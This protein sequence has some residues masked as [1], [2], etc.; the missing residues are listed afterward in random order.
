MNSLYLEEQDITLLELLYYF[1]L[2]YSKILCINI[3]IFFLV[4]CKMY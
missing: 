3:S 2:L 4:S 1:K